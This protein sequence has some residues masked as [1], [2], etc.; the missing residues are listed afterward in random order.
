MSA[1]VASASA[2]Q[3]NAA[4]AARGQAAVHLLE[5]RAARRAQTRAVIR[6]CTYA[7]AVRGAADRDASATAS[8]ARARARAATEPFV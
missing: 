2:A 6:W 5:G 3:V 4:A 1:M 8:A 7:R